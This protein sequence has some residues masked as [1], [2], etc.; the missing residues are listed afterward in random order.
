MKKKKIVFVYQCDVC[1][2][3]ML[4]DHALDLRLTT[5]LGAARA[6]GIHTTCN[7]ELSC[8]ETR[9]GKGP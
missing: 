3:R 7:G 5:H 8:V 4:T 9:T 1:R 2:A 6:Q